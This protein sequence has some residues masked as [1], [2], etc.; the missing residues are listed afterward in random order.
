MDPGIAA[1]HNDVAVE[2]NNRGDAD[3]AMKEYETATKIDSNYA[4][5]HSNLGNL[6]RSLKKD[7]EAAAEYAEAIMQYLRHLEGYPKDAAAHLNLAFVLRAGGDAVN[8]ATE[9]NAAIAELT[10]VVQNEPRNILFR[11]YLGD[12]LAAMRKYD[13]AAAAYQEAIELN[14]DAIAV[15]RNRGEALRMAKKYD[16]AAAEFRQAIKA[17][18]KYALA[19]NDLGTAL[20]AM[21][22]RD[23]AIA[24]FRAAIA[25]DPHFARSK[26]TRDIPAP[27]SGWGVCPPP[28]ASGMKRSRNFA[29]RSTP[30]STMPSP[31]P[32]SP[33]R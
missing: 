12:A 10:D 8:A 4:M 3:G 13:A 17:E 25:V 24:E 19:H 1:A 29:K 27:M 33:S 15:H 16:E 9:F 21:G 31:M 14:P 26:A 32:I 22:K 18:P 5:A 7:R 6:Q 28:P 23:D 11:K 20:G 30:I 2:L